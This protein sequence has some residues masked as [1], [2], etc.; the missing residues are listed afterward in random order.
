MDTPPNEKNLRTVPFVA[1]ATRGLIRDQKMRRPIMFALLGV[2]VVM[3]V[4]GSTFLLEL[5]NPREHFGWF[6]TYWLVCAW[7]TATSFL[8]ALFDLLIV[9]AEARAARK[10]LREQAASVRAA[11][12]EE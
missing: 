2:G 11:S 10:L 6:A 4:A 1:H 8:L 9:R 12:E 3:V 7:V 5:L